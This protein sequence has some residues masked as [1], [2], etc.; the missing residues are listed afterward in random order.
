MLIEKN[1]EIVR[2]NKG[3]ITFVKTV[4]EDPTANKFT[5]VVKPD[6]GLTSSRVIEKKNTAAG[7]GDDELLVTYSDGT[8][9]IK[10]FYLKEDTEGLTASNYYYDILEEIPDDLNSGTTHFMGTCTIIPTVQSP[11]DG[12][13]LPEDAVRYVIVPLRRVPPPSHYNSSGTEGMEAWDDDYFYKAVGDCLWG[14]MP[15]SKNF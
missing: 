13:D 11:Y 12:T 7:G 9:T 8:L 10:M 2:F 5:F 4:D 3:S 6:K 15:L 1:I 14:R